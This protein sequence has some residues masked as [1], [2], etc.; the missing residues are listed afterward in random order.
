MKSTFYVSSGVILAVLI[1]S[2]A[3]IPSAFASNN[4]YD[5]GYG[6]GCDDAGIS[7]P[8][9]RYINQP[10]RGPSFHTGAF[11]DGYNAGIGS[12]SGS[13]NDND[14]NDNNGNDNDNDG[15]SSSDDDII[16]KACDAIRENPGAAEGILSMLGLPGVGTVAQLG[17]SLGN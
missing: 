16:D 1:A 9:D 10:E 4:A 5:S 3:S 17:C 2:I 7:D 15:G 14:E 11:M 6:H 8:N 13:G 12:C